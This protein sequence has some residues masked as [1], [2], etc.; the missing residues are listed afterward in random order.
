MAQDKL[1]IDER[2][3]ANGLPRAMT[4]ER[5]ETDCYNLF[6]STYP[7]EPKT[8]RCQPLSDMLSIFVLMLGDKMKIGST[9]RVS[10]WLFVLIL[11]V[12]E[13]SVLPRI[14]DD[15]VVVED[16]V[17]GADFW[18]V[19]VDGEATPRV[20]QGF[21]ITKV[22][23]ALLKPGERVLHLSSKPPIAANGKLLQIQSRIKKGCR[24]RIGRDAN[25]APYLVKL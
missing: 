13:L 3:S 17:V 4:H 5:L 24:Y 20:R 14:F 15:R 18:I 7:A 19:K 9:I 1:C 25:G 8:P 22:P 10:L 11:A 23:F 21:L 12:S 6:R 16:A 2:C